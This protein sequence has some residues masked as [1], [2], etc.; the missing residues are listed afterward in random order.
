MF[1]DCMIVDEG[2]AGTA[3]ASVKG[4]S[5]GQNSPSSS[6]TSLICLGDLELRY[7]ADALI[8]SFPL[9]RRVFGHVAE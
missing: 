4:V 2:V 9:L 1:S 7:E 8:R 6:P 3:I 5:Q